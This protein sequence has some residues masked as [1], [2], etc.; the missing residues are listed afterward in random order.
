MEDLLNTLELIPHYPEAFEKAKEDHDVP[1]VTTLPC[2]LFH[3]SIITSPQLPP[4]LRYSLL[5]HILASPC[6]ETLTNYKLVN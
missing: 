4:S 3:S 1:R 6:C 2:L 5:I